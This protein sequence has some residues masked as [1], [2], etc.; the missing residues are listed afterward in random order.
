[1][2]KK[3]FLIQMLQEL[4]EEHGIVRPKDLLEKARPKNSPLHPYFDW[5]DKKAAENYRIWQAQHLIASVRVE[6]SGQE[7]D[8]YW[9]AS[10]VVQDMKLQGYFSTQKVLNDDELYQQ[11]LANAVREISYWQRKYK[12]IEAL[13]DVVNMQE[14]ENINRK[15]LKNRPAM[16]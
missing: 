10:V 14:V 15:V 16:P 12:E 11:I 2:N 6:I 3:E 7:A 13:K 8:A 9:N 5:D 1:M 4:E